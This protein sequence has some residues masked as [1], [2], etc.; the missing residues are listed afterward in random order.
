[1]KTIPCMYV[2]QVVCIKSDTEARLNPKYV[3]LLTC[4]VVIPIPI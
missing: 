3:Y 4:Y 2:L 1:M